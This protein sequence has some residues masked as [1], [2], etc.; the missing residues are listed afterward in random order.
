MARRFRH[1]I[2][3]RDDLFWRFTLLAVALTSGFG[4]CMGAAILFG[5]SDNVVLRMISALGTMFSA[6]IGLGSGYLLGAAATGYTT[7]T[8]EEDT[9][10]ERAAP[11]NRHS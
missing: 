4:V 6:V 11:P 1:R 3:N 9:D 2:E 10:G 8:Q 7:E 5:A